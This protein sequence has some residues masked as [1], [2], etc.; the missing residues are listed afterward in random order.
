MAMLCLITGLL[1]LAGALFLCYKPIIPATLIG[2]GAM[3]VLSYGN[4]VTFSKDT[5]MFWGA[6]TMI[7]LVI[8]SSQAQDSSD[9]KGSGYI[10]TGAL[11]GSIIGMLSTHAGIIIGAALGAILGFVA[12][13]RT[14]QGASI[15]LPSKEFISQLAAKGLPTVVTI[16]ILCTVLDNLLTNVTT[17][18]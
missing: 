12:Y 3:W 18:N 13:C 5:L 4:H 2:Y 16:S 11:V 9:A 14:P 1:L 10:A 6:A 15:K 8:Y 7:V 17:I